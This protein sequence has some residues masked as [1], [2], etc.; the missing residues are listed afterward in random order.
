[1]KKEAN[2]KTSTPPPEVSRHPE[3]EKD[4]WVKTSMA[5]RKSVWDK[6]DAICWY[7]RI[8]MRAGLDELLT[9]FVEKYKADSLAALEAGWEEKGKKRGRK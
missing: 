4:V 3:D 6:F 1:M 8:P 9:E 7:R 5:T 2:S